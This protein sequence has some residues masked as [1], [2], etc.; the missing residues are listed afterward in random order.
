MNAVFTL[1]FFLTNYFLL[2]HILK[3]LYVTVLLAYEQALGLRGWRRR[4]GAGEEVNFPPP[5]PP[6]PKKKK[7]LEPESLFAG[8]GPFISVFY[9]S[10]RRRFVLQTEISGKY[11]QLFVFYFTSVLISSPCCKDQ[12][13]AFTFYFQIFTKDP[14]LSIGL[15][16]WLCRYYRLW[17]QTTAS[18][19]LKCMF[20]Y[21]VGQAFLLLT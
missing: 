15:W 14:A 6:P 17:Y 2:C 10:P 18:L 7:N 8:Y 9:T 3:V 20:F 11:I 21:F 4:R 1:S 19:F 13:A 12:F 5:P 16:L